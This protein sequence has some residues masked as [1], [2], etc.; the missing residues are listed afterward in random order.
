MK[1]AC[2]PK[3]GRGGGGKR[4]EREPEPRQLKLT[5]MVGGPVAPRKNGD[6]REEDDGGRR[7]ALKCDN[8]AT[9]GATYAVPI[10]DLEEGWEGAA[11]YTDLTL[12]PKTSDC[13][14]EVPT[15]LVTPFSDA[16][17]LHLPRFE[18]MR[19]FG[20]CR[21]TRS[22]GAP[23]HDDVRF[24]GELCAKKPPQ[25]A[26]T[27]AVM[28]QLGVWGGAMLIL[29]CGFGKTVCALWLIKQLGRRALVVVNS[30]NLLR[31]WKKRIGQFLPSARVGVI[32]QKKA[33]GEGCDVVIATLQ[34]LSKRQYAPELLA[35]FG[36]VVIDEAHHI[37]APMFSKALRKLPARN[38]VGLSAT[39]DRPDGCARALNWFMGP[40]AYRAQ[41]VWERVDV[42][43]VQYTRGCEEELV[44]RGN[45]KLRYPEMVNRMVEDPV[46][47]AWITSLIIKYYR[48]GRHVLVLCDRR[49][50]VRDLA[51]LIRMAEHEL[52][53]GVVLGGMKEKDSDPAL[54]M[55]VIVSTY[56][57][58]SEGAD[59]PRLDTLV[60][61]T[62]RGNIEQAL[63][64]ILRAHPEKATPLVIDAC[65]CF[66]L[67]N[68][69]MWKR[70]R[71]YTKF[72]YRVVRV[73]DDDEEEKEEGTK[74]VAGKGERGIEAF[75]LPGP[76]A[77]L[78]P[79]PAATAAPAPFPFQLC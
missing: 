7:P 19:L 51:H 11:W 68:G 71:F 26:A 74:I 55:Q 27:R 39:P 6:W 58:F 54:G 29:P 21:D 73:R 53:V 5:D 69:M 1:R 3:G 25:V 16:D 18:G 48:A 15:P 63:G 46:R 33:D 59:V 67:F 31:Q 62:P 22:L 14:S 2:T 72:G 40:E 12:I 65:D 60:F 28:E 66:S 17:T 36:T 79:A 50:Q 24:A 23:L 20:P 42:R 49:D 45:G 32:Q 37:A 78:G 34:S 75:L 35:G 77:V 44:Y 56:H 57:Y 64:R 10:A 8:K 47:E 70:H 52:E 13:G 30:S 9:L 43:M 41:R 4:R 76:A 38:V 61:A